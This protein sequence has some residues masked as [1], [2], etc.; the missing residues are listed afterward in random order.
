ME[1]VEALSTKMGIMVK[2]G[3][4]KCFGSIQHIR[5]KFGTG[6]VIEIKIRTLHEDEFTELWG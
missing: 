6:Y 5:H 4:F 3:V 2:G 1:E